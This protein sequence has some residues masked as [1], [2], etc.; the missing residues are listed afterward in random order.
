[1]N[2]PLLFALLIAVAVLLIFIG[3]GRLLSRR[4]PVGSR[5]QQY[6]A[7]IN[8]ESIPKQTSE[9][10]PL[11][12]LVNRLVNGFG[13]APRLALLL[14]Q[15]DTP[16]TVP[17]FSALVMLASVF[18]LGLGWL[19]DNLFIGIL[20]AALFGVIPFFYLKF[21]QLRR[22]RTFANQLP[23]VLTLLV[24]AL[25]AG[26]GLNQAIGVL[27]E[28]LPPPSS[29]EFGRIQRAVNLGVP[30]QRALIDRSRVLA[31][32]DLDLVVTAINVQ[33]EVGGNLAQ[34]LDTIGDTIRDRIRIMREIRVLTAQQRL[35]GYVLVGVPIFVAVSLS[36]VA[37]GYFDPFFEPGIASILPYIAFSMLTIAFLLIR[38]IMNI[39][40]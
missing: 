30:L 1:M 6:G 2:T 38:W 17:E 24:G 12:R 18:G 21:V 8:E 35:T 33:Y 34:V 26:Y 28:Q 3:L 40:V 23:D 10:R 29:T 16:L 5:L 27:V 32:D 36:I 39:K 13:L 15:A 9:Q 31:N 25:R 19:R 37:P 20:A 7:P 14:A 22:Q 11:L 4:D